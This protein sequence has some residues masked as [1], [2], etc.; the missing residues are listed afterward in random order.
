MEYVSKDNSIVINGEFGDID[1]MIIN[2]QVFNLVP[3]T[4]PVVDNPFSIG[5]YVQVITPKRSGHRL[6]EVGKV[7]DFTPEERWDDESMPQVY[8]E[9]ATRVGSC[10]AAG[11]L[12]ESGHGCRMPVSGLAKVS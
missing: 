11:G 8:V 12:V 3:N 9:F 4:P 10:G 7:V 2:G 1:N 5:D 6:L